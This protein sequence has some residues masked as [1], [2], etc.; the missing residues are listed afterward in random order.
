MVTPV[1]DT[2]LKLIFI[3]QL[4]VSFFFLLQEEPTSIKLALV[5]SL[6]MSRSTVPILISPGEQFWFGGLHARFVRLF[7]DG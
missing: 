3:T 7:S 1:R 4:G 6:E 2:R 5:A